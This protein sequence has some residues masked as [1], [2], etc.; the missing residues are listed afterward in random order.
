MDRPRT[1][2]RGIWR[3]RLRPILF[4]VGAMLALLVVFAVLAIAFARYYTE[5]G[6]N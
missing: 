6:G 5:K 4:V 1:D 3:E 2:R